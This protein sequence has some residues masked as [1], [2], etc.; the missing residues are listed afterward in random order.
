MSRS[1]GFA[2]VLQRILLDGVGHAMKTLA[3]VDKATWESSVGGSHAMILLTSQLF[4][5]LHTLTGNTSLYTVDED[6]AL[7]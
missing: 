3:E 4:S 7:E 6:K 2:P 1:N 5:L